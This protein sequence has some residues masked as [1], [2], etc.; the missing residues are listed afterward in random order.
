MQQENKKQKRI[1]F[2]SAMPLQYN[3]SANIRNLALIDGLC[4]NGYVV[5]VLTFE[6]NKESDWFDSSMDVSSVNQFLYRGKDVARSKKR[7]N[8]EHTGTANTIKQIATQ[9]IKKVVKLLISLS[10]W[11]VR[12][13]SARKLQDYSIAEDYD[14]IISSSDPKSSH[15]LGQKIYSRNKDKIGKWIQYWGDPF[16]MDIN[17]SGGSQKRMQKAEARILALADKI[18]YVSPFTLECQKKLFP[19]YQD[20]MIFLPIPVKS[21]HM[22]STR[23][24]NKHCLKIGYYGA[25]YNRR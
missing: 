14:I 24:P 2:V 18:V 25:Y 11:D 16:T 7:N 20:K 13:I 21:K 4:Q 5:D 3:V 19:L 22:I 15:Y 8:T 23:E 17:H 10:V 9:I 6:P 1:L 12:I